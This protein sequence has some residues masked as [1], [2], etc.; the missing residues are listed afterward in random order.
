PEA[1]ARKLLEP[2]DNKL[3]EMAFTADMLVA[4]LDDD[5]RHEI[6]EYKRLRF[7]IFWFFLAA[8]TLV[9][10]YVHRRIVRPVR[11]LQRAARQIAK[12]N[13]DLHVDV[14][15]QDEIGELGQAFNRMA[16]EISIAFGEVL[17]H[18]EDIKALN[19]ALQKFV[20]VQKK[21]ELYV[22]ICERSRE[23]FGLRVSWLGLLNEGDRDVRIVASSGADAAFLSSMRVTWDESAYGMGPEG[24]AIKTDLV[25]IINDME[26][27][28][29]TLPGIEAALRQGYRSC[30]VQPLIFGNCAVIG[31]MVFYSDQKDHFTANMVDLCEIF[32]NH[33]ASVMENVVLLKDL[34]DRVIERTGKLQDALLL[35]QSANMAKTDFLAN[36]SHD[37]R[38]PLNAIIGFSEALSHG[39]YG[40]MKDEHTEYLTYIYQSGIKLLK[41]INEILDLSKMESGAMGL[42]YGECNFSDILNSALYIFKEKIKKHGIEVSTEV[43]DETK[44]LVIDQSKI[45]QVIVNLLTDSIRAT[46]DRG[47]ITIKAEKVSCSI[48]LESCSP[49]ETTAGDSA[50]R[51]CIEVSVTDTR[52][53]LS[54]EDRLRFFEPYKQF[55]AAVDRKQ[56]SISLLLS[57]R[58]IEMHGGRIWAEAPAGPVTEGDRI[59][60]NRFI[61]ILPQRPCR[62]NLN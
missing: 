33:A 44:A 21:E 61:F 53:G 42:E 31:V 30:L 54:S 6:R 56:E 59:Q 51:S 20:S 39:I 36:M 1:E 19:R 26:L 4:F 3:T 43:S 9:I 62:D 12:G 24:K 5:Y 2:F 60:G 10:F 25:Q 58:F 40:E 18:T 11:A 7:Y 27:A 38:T 41:L 45:K 35:A 57:K 14:K 13:Y 29:T 34:E 15:T 23:L 17:W 16:G 55:D 22:A 46:P 52:P 47:R 49:E 48:D 28:D 32:T 50:D 37:L 8:G